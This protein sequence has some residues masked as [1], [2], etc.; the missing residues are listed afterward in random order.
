MNKAEII[1][2]AKQLLASID[3][4]YLERAPYEAAEDMSGTIRTLVEALQESQK[5]VRELKKDRNH[6]KAIAEEFWEEIERRNIEDEQI[7][8]ALGH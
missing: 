8:N 3:N 4:G 6:H 7:L 2:N 1:K 5:K